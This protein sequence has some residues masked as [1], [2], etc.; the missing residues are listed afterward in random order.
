[1][2]KGN[3]RDLAEHYHSTISKVW[4]VGKLLIKY[5][6]EKGESGRKRKRE[7]TVDEEKANTNTIL[8]K[9]G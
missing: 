1:M 2:W 8:T 4:T 3:S 5:T 6:G 9:R 7:E